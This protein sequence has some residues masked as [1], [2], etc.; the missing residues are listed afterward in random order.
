MLSLNDF[1]VI[2]P[3]PAKLV[4][5][6][7]T[8]SLVALSLII[9]VGAS[10]MALVLA[11]AA[12][13][14][15]SP[16]MERLHLFSGAIAL[17][18]GIW[19]M[20]FI[21]MLAFEMPIPVDYDP[22]IT[23][24]SVAPSLLASWVTLSLLAHNDMTPTRLALG[25]ITVGA[26]IGAMHYLGMAAMQMGPTLRYDPILFAV[27]ILVAVLLG[28]VA[29]WISFG[30]RRRHLL[31]GYKRRLLAGTVMGLAIAAMHYTAMEAA[32]FIGEPSPGFLPGSNRHLILALSIAFV[33]V[34]LSLMAAGVNAV[35]RYRALMQRSQQTASE[36]KTVV[37]AAVDGIIKISERGK[38]LSFNDSAERIFGYEAKEV[39]GKNVKILMPEPHQSAHDGY[40]DNYLRTGEQKIIGTGRE[41]WALH[42]DGHEFPIRLAIGEARLNG[43]ST[44]V[45]F[46]TDISQ[47][48]QME[49]DLLRAKEE[50]EQAAEAKSAFLANMSH[51]IRTPMNSIIGFTD[52]V[53]GSPLTD[54]QTKHLS[55]VKTSARSLLALLNDI[56]DTAKLDGGH[57]ELECRDFSLRAVCEQIVASQSLQA[58]RKNLYLT[59]DYQAEDHFQGD[60]LRVQ[61]I[62][63]NLVTNA[64]KFTHEGGVKL[65]VQQEKSGKLLILVEDTGIGIPADRIDHIF[66]P[67]TQADSSMTRRFGGTG[68]G[69]TIARQLTELMG[70]EIRVSSKPGQGSTFRVSLPLPPG[71]AVDSNPKTEQEV[72]LPRLSF[73]VADDVKQNL[74][75]LSILLKERGHDVE[76]ARNGE[77]ALK[78]FA[79]KPFD[80]VLMDVQM[81]EMNGHEA[82]RR[83]RQLETERQQSPTPVIALTASVLEQDR[84]EASEAGMDGFAIKPID[85]AELTTEISRILGLQHLNKAQKIRHKAKS[86]AEA[87]NT[88]LI[89]QL[90][91]DSQA[92]LKA[93]RQF[94]Q[95]SQNQPETLRHQTDA[96]PIAHRLRGL[97]GN[98]GFAPLAAT[99]AEIE[100]TLKK[101]L[102]VSEGLWHQ[103]DEQ[104]QAAK[105]WHDRQHNE[106]APLHETP[107]SFKPLDL[108]ALDDLLERLQ[109][110]EV[111]EDIFNRIRPSLPTDCAEAAAEAL[112]NFDPQRAAQLL[113]AHR[114]TIKEASC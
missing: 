1:F 77:E 33:T 78:L 93:A 15:T 26:G 52:L 102:T 82:T 22:T 94:L 104:F 59:L 80:I 91:P 63:L 9:A 56:L 110:G 24:F 109:H 51:E 18:F 11:A 31:T 48:H 65:Q 62:L 36:L 29:L 2:G 98:L 88:S 114:D 17:G 14:S 100:V 20:H 27:S 41:V 28:T 87:V 111:P 69:T 89:K 70:G 96:A 46:I 21:G 7:Y 66:E 95:A 101:Q 97:A 5:G 42:K 79:A 37:D 4:S 3:S 108:S 30:L 39:L 86:S 83:I 50:A 57:T 58:G 84:R 32:R 112:D 75:L 23:L 71:T 44:F 35:A 8:P 64:V 16:L 54:T 76:T 105:D 99:L 10:Y 25:G 38:I 45:G 60:P 13:R 107:Q 73:L 103:L 12:R 19:S 68:L 34:S 53:L 55:V 43:S 72:A 92:H 81:P 6:Q 40:L 85:L 67:F 113:K 106:T 74:E 47:R 61:Q 90:W 49:T